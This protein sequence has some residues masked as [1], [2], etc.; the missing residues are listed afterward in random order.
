MPKDT[1]DFA[2]F[3]D[4]AV[5]S[6]LAGRSP[7]PWRSNRARE[8]AIFCITCQLRFLPHP[9][10]SP[11]RPSAAGR[12][13]TVMLPRCQSR[14][15]GSSARSSTTR[16]CSRL[17][18][19]KLSRS[20]RCLLR[21]PQVI[22]HL[23]AIDRSDRCLRLELDEDFAKTD[24]VD[25]VVNRQELTFVVNRQADLARERN[26]SE[27]QLD[28]EGLG[29]DRF[30]KPTADLAMDF[31]SGAV[32]L[33][34][35]VVSERC[36]VG[37]R[38]ARLRCSRYADQKSAVWPTIRSSTRVDVAIPAIVFPRTHAVSAQRDRRDRDRRDT[39]SARVGR[40]PAR[41]RSSR[42]RKH[43]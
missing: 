13:D 7:A 25:P 40:S 5:A 43:A 9:V 32:D 35:L 12:R 20:A 4:G 24:E 31:E 1:A 28:C 42:V 18:G 36:L 37:C 3:A 19:P 14:R 27:S 11:A 33:V 10:R 38:H 34:G 26:F 17:S 6:A 22:Q 41:C 15:T 16:L 39:A 30:G 29:V 2:D 21:R 8:E 23:A